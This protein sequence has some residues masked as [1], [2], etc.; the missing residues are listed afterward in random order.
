MGDPRMLRLVRL[1]GLGLLSGLAVVMLSLPAAALEAEE[2][3]E[4]DYQRTAWYLVG[5]VAFADTLFDNQP[6]FG[7]GWGFQF[8]GGFRAIEHFAVELEYEYFGHLLTRDGS[9]RAKVE[10]NAFTV[11]TKIPFFS[12]QLQPFIH[13]GLGAIFVSSDLELSNPSDFAMRFG[14]GLD[15]YLTDHIILNTTIDYLRGFGD[16]DDYRWLSISAGVG[17][18]F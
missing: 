17:Y 7:T 3:E 14:G 9:P 15:I 18:R 10:L 5:S 11:N 1:I 16:V 6:N 8:R 13:Y 12:G 4:I 2:E